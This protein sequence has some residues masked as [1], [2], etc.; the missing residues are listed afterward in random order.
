[1]ARLTASE[2]P[3]NIRYK[4]L[5]NLACEIRV[6][7][8]QPARRLEDV[9]VSRLITISP[10]RSDVEIIGLSSLL[11]DLETT[12]VIYVDGKPFRTTAHMAQ[13]L[14]HVR[15]VFLPESRHDRDCQPA[16]APRTRSWLPQR[17][18]KLLGMPQKTLHVW[19]DSICINPWDDE[20]M[21]H[22]R[23][24]M[25][26]VYQAAKTVLGW[27]GPKV[28]C[29]DVGLTVFSQIDQCMPRSWGDPGDAE[30]HPENYAP[31]HEWAKNIRNLWQTSEYGCPPFLMPPW[32]GANDFMYRPYFQ[33]QCTSIRN[34]FVSTSLPQ[35]KQ[36]KPPIPLKNPKVYHIPY[37]LS[38]SQPSPHLKSQDVPSPY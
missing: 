10:T 21:S 14:R 18:R 3:H 6:L 33:K 30:L 36:D 29:T 1:M 28:D 17:L 34:L 22:H 7:E 27:L 15:D 8:I 24:T 16:G 4:K 19:L 11:G 25:K 12:E 31:R 5:A 23:E 35:N 20:E 37:N 9:V 26:M 2:R 38:P 13:A 32:V